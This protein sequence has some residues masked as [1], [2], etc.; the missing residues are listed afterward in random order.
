MSGHAGFAPIGNQPVFQP[1]GIGNVGNNIANGDVRQP[2]A[3]SLAQENNTMDT[4]I[5][6]TIEELREA[7]A[8]LE[9]GGLPERFAAGHGIQ[10][11]RFRFEWRD[12]ALSLDFDLPCV[13]LLSDEETQREEGAEAAAAARMGML[14]LAARRDGMLLQEGE[15]SLTASCSETGTYYETHDAEGEVLDSGDDWKPLAA[16]LETVFGTAEASDTHT[17]IIWP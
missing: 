5:D 15:A 17:A 6:Q 16:R 8:T 11:R 13:R 9:Q 4:T 10:S 12:E 7:A 2:N 3:H 14:L 1:N